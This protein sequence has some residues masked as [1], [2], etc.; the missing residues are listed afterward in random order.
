MTEQVASAGK[1]LDKDLYSMIGGAP[2]ISFVNPSLKSTVDKP[3]QWSHKPFLHPS[4]GDALILKHWVRD[5]QQAEDD[6]YHFSK[7]NR[8][9]DVISYTDDDY[10]KYLTDTDWSKEETDYLF[11]IC[12][13]YDLR[14]PVIF[15]RYNYNASTRTL[16]DMKDRYYSVNRKLI[17]VR[18]GLTDD[19]LYD[20]RLDRQTLLQYYAFDK[21]KEADRKQ[22]LL[23]LY[24]RTKEQL[25]EEELLFLEARRMEEN[26]EALTTQREL[27]YS[28]LHLE[29]AQQIPATPLTPLTGSYAGRS[30]S[31]SATTA[32]SSHH[33][34]TPTSANATPTA[35]VAS[36]NA[37]MSS[38]GGIGITGGMSSAAEKQKKRKDK[39]DILKKARRISTSSPVEELLPPLPD[40]KEK[41]IP[42]VYVRSQKLPGV[43]TTMQTRV[44]RTM[45]DLGIG[46]RPTMPTKD[47]CY[48][49]DHLQNTVVTLLEIRKVAE[50][51]NLDH[52]M[53]DKT[54]PGPSSVGRKHGLPG[55]NRGGSSA[56]GSGDQR[57]RKLGQ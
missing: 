2:P 28:T 46:A 22:G 55:G 41:L 39:E 47:V 14:F 16:E 18:G 54:S 25:E 5:D 3:R 21:N 57:R 4:R 34:P 51:L 13:Q 42:G 45:S 1:R 17:K 32:S 12:R 48:K 10:E 30:N 49:Y 19:D 31:N 38:P 23:R 33:L 6:D 43:K 53:P 36:N 11:K 56:A 52:R 44:I 7:F 26:K 37:S 40:K 8:I 35:S 15:D 29:Q 27:L 50:K 24:Q 20:S 9:I